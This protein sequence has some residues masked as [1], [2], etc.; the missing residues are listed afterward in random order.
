MEKRQKHKGSWMFWGSFSGAA[1]K[2]PGVFW[3]KEWGGIKSAFYYEHIVSIIDAWLQYY[4]A[5]HG[6][7]LYLMHDG[8]PEHRARVTRAN[9]ANRAIQ[10]IS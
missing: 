4:R 2:E 8:A 3:E 7:K 1:G 10:P 5:K 9:L 6:E